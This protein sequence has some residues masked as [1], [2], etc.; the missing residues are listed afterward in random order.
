MFALAVPTSACAADSDPVVVSSGSII[1]RWS[2]NGTFDPNLCQD[3]AVDRIRIIVYDGRNAF[4]G[5]WIAP[6]Q[7]FTTR[8]DLLPGQYRAEV[9]LVGTGGVESTT[10]RID[11]FTIVSR[12]DHVVDIDFPASSFS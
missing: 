3:A 6:C 12:S 8:I 2:I 1:L 5:E 11:P 9:A 4:I 10:V 7:D